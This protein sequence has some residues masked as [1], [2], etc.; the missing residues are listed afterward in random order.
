MR[1]QV[2]LPQE[3]LMTSNEEASK[4]KKV[5]ED[6]DLTTALHRRNFETGGNAQQSHDVLINEC[7]GLA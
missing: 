2:F 6:L 1:E 5:R 4:T 3:D 7:G